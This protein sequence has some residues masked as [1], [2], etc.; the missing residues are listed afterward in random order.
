MARLQQ[1]EA[2]LEAPLEAATPLLELDLPAASLAP[3]IAP[4]EPELVDLL[5]APSLD[6]VEAPILVGP[7]LYGCILR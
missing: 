6:L 5:E 7:L 3:L 1:P 2:P 4:L